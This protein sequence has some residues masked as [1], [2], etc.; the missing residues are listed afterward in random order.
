MR[1][2]AR[3]LDAT[4]RAAVKLLFKPAFKSKDQQKKLNLSKTGTR[5]AVKQTWTEALMSLSWAKIEAFLF[6]NMPDHYPLSKKLA[7]TKSQTLTGKLW[8]VLLIFMSVLACATYVSETYEGSYFAVQIYGYIE[9]A[10]TQFFAADFLYNFCASSNYFRYLTDGWTLVDIITIVPVYITIGLQASTGGS[11]AVN[12]SIFR[13]VRILRLIRILRMFKLLNTLSG[14]E[15]QLVTLS[16]TLISLIFMAAGVVHLMEND[17]KQALFYNCNF[18]NE[19]TGWKPSCYNDRSFVVETDLNCECVGR[20]AT[21]DYTCMPN[22]EYGDK[23]GEPSGISC[24]VLTFLDALY[25]VVVTVATV[26]YGDISPTTQVSKAVMMAFIVIS[27][28]LIP[29]Q[30]NALTEL[31][32]ANSQYRQPFNQSSGE[33]HVIICGYIADWRKLEK[34][35]KEFF[36]PDRNYSAAPD[37][38]ALI[39]SPVEPNDD[40]K[41]LMYNSHFDGRIS[42]LIGSSLSI[43]DLQKARADVASA[44]FFF[45]NAE[46][47]EENAT[48]D[49]AATVLRTLSVSNFNPNLDCFVQVLKP[50]DRDILKDSDVEMVFCLD[51]YKTALQAR[52]AMCPGLSTL[53]E[54][55]FHSFSEPNIF[56]QTSAEN[57]L[58]R[59]KHSDQW[60]FEYQEG[61]TVEPYFIPLASRYA[62]MLSYEWALMVEGIYL[63]WDVVTVGVASSKDHTLILNPSRQETKKYKYLSRF[64]DKYN[65]L[66]ILASEQGQASQIASALD[67]ASMIDKILNKMLVAEE[68]FTVRK[69]KQKKDLNKE[70]KNK[71]IVSSLREIIRVAKSW[72][73]GSNRSTVTEKIENTDDEDDEFARYIA[74]QQKSMGLGGTASE[75]QTIA[76]INKLKYAA[77]SAAL[78]QSED[79]EEDDD[80]VGGDSDK[81]SERNT[82]EKSKSSPSNKMMAK[83]RRGSSF[84]VAKVEAATAMQHSRP[85]LYPSH[86]Q[87]HTGSF[88]SVMEP[89]RV[90]VSP[91][92]IG[93]RSSVSVTSG[94]PVGVPKLRNNTVIGNSDEDANNDSVAS[95]SITSPGGSPG[96]TNRERT[97]SSGS[98]VGTISNLEVALGMGTASNEVED[99][100]DLGGHIIVFGC[101]TLIYQFISEVRKE[102]HNAYLKDPVAILVVDESPPDGWDAICEM[103][104][105]V[106]YLRGKM[107][108]STD[109][110]RT[111]IEHANSVV[112]LAGRDSVT[113]VEEE[114]LDAEALFAYLK[115]EKYVPKHVFFTV[116]LTC[117]SNMAVLNS[118]VL[119]QSRHQ[120]S[121]ADSGIV[122]PNNKK[123]SKKRM[124]V[125]ER[126]IERKRAAHESRLNI[127]TEMLKGA[128]CSHKAVMKEEYFQHLS[129][130]TTKILSNIPGRRVSSLEAMDSTI[131]GEGIRKK[132]TAAQR[133][134]AFW[135][136]QDSHHLLAV[137]ASGNAFVP[138]SFDS[139]LASSFYSAFLPLLAESIICGSKHQSIHQIDVPIPFIGRFFVDLFRAFQSRNLL[140]IAIYRAPLS[141][142]GSILPYVFTAPHAEVELR[143]GDKVFVIA[144]PAILAESVP[145]LGER[146]VSNPDG[147]IS[148]DHSIGEQLVDE[149]H[150]DH[151]KIDEDAKDLSDTTTRDNKKVT[152]T[153]TSPAGLLTQP[154]SAVKEA[155]SEIHFARHGRNIIDV[156]QMDLGSH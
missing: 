61:L 74:G 67:D 40:L 24:E 111:N 36:H 38:H 60:T 94:L 151:R 12:L 59:S 84:N 130:S 6:P 155:V 146:L 83:M 32:A 2:A 55:L 108:R 72:S 152:S 17:L 102:V 148:L 29:V 125:T 44:M 142:N 115:L 96:H 46:T 113:R 22:Y 70:E 134:E 41:A 93:R 33:S 79:D 127:R 49:D 31:L 23:Q 9:M 81:E 75:A 153:L 104:T 57:H 35:L 91:S 156:M 30:V 19:A 106:L 101:T 14:V 140:I 100:I 62:E 122:M 88:T 58:I 147:S 141:S 26:G 66:I 37:F 80:Y 99:A 73:G 89:E 114:N 27:F 69:V 121:R 110:N 112:L 139:M 47:P 1:R 98:A 118:T 4:G 95:V 124:S 52:N 85:T 133:L 28:I 65:M 10:I 53:V 64:F 18:I 103:F 97:H 77:S 16:L 131:V 8:D 48:L 137:F 20:T 5:A 42:Y 107:T 7:L 43:E 15:R 135:T 87:R 126:E 63:E 149:K 119:R 138:A 109:F 117:A 39:M 3:R 78:S 116:E 21:I 136:M 90:G 105:N 128:F 143:Y 132:Q 120:H 71:L 82:N 123:R 13:F 54:N 34:F 45:C 154:T 56:T 92:A 51:E 86:I 11:V 50:E 150:A 76:R 144:N 129:K 25:F 68:N 145:I